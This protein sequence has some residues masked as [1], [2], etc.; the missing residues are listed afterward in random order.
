MWN[1]CAK[2]AAYYLLQRTNI[3]LTTSGALRLHHIHMVG[4]VQQ[5]VGRGKSRGKHF[6]QVML[7]TTGEA[8]IPRFSSTLRYYVLDSCKHWHDS[9]E[10]ELT[11]RTTSQ[12][13]FQHDSWDYQ[14]CTYLRASGTGYQG[15]V[16]KYDCDAT[17]KA[18]CQLTWALRE[19][20]NIVFLQSQFSRCDNTT[21]VADKSGGDDVCTQCASKWKYKDVEYYGC[22]EVESDNEPWCATEVDGNYDYARYGYCNTGC[23]SSTCSTCRCSV[24]GEDWSCCNG[25]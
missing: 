9:W 20:R 4:I 5:G 14:K 15:F 6:P 8:I 21:C 7:T 16:T 13:V 2:K 23:S 18:I 24:S 25:R 22:T 1:A 19:V 11:P 17:N 12:I 10:I 3:G